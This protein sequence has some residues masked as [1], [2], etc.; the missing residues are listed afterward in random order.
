MGQEDERETRLRQFEGFGV[1]DA[2]MTHA[3]NNAIFLHCLP[4]KRGY[5]VSDDVVDGPQSRVWQQAA[6]RMHTAR[7]VLLWLFGSAQ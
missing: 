5:E 6:N 2:L 1:D 4:A 3:A 7:G